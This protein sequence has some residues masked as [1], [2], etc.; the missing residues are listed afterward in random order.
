MRAR[1]PRSRPDA[2]AEVNHAAPETALVHQVEPHADVVGEGPFAAS[3]HDRRYEQVALVDQSGRERLGG[4]AGAAYG[5]VTFRFY[6]HLPD[7]FGVNSRS[8]RVLALDT[9]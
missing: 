3:Y 5:E 8:I 6:L 2:V 4:E 9:V 1:W 7:G